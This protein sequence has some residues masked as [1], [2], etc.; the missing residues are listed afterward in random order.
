LKILIVGDFYPNEKLSKDLLNKEPNEVFGSF[1]KQINEADLAIVNLESPLT[2]HSIQINK[3]GPALKADPNI[4]K[5]IKKAGFKLATLANNHVLDFG[6]IGIKDTIET[7]NQNNIDFLGAGQNSIQAGKPYI[8][9]HSSGK[10]LAVL[11]FA[12]NEWST[13]NS[14]KTG[15]NGID[16]V[17]NFYAI[18]K[19]KLEADFVLVITHGGHENFNL[20]SLSYRNLLR[21]YVDA[22][23]DAVINHHTHN[24]SGFENYNR[25]P[26]Y[27]SIGNFLFNGQDSNNLSYWNKGLAVEIGFNLNKITANHYCFIQAYKDKI[28][29]ILKGEDLATL[30][31]EINRLSKIINSDQE[32]IQGFEIWKKSSKSYYKYNIEPH[33][34]RILQFLQNRGFA[35]SLWSAKKKKYLL[36]MLRSESHR[37][38]LISLLEDENSNS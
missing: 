16:P 20:P 17:S 27:Y 1:F 18:K 19:A 34:N 36:N 24:I 29:E 31:T 4:A 37:E 11:N 28:F 12:E 32:L 15:A 2:N 30:N 21:Y 35:P 7:L 10:T 26:I 8:F 3:T 25:K 22:G 23:A 38:L 13:T 14:E 9:K 33:G 6:E 5:F